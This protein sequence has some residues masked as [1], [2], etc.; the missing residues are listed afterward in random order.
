VIIRSWG[1]IA[2]LY[3]RGI[4][5]PVLKIARL[6]LP[7]KIARNV[8]EN[9]RA[10]GRRDISEG[11]PKGLTAYSS[12]HHGHCMQRYTS[13]LPALHQGRHLTVQSSYLWRAIVVEQRVR[14]SS[15]RL[16][17]GVSW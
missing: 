9:L 16:A 1:S 7:L 17:S 13:L 10:F 3:D 4:A 11:M 5:A 12:Q 15:H 2:N 6:C 8:L 14:G